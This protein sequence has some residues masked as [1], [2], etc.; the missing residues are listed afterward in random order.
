MKDRRVACN[1]P[2]SRGATVIA[3]LRR[4]A[5]ILRTLI[6]EMGALGCAKYLMVRSGLG[7]NDEFVLHTKQALHPLLPRRR[8]SDLDSYRQVFIEREYAPFA[9]STTWRPW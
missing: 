4:R 7:T 1:P 2:S 3:R 5:R 6:P 8:S 9:T